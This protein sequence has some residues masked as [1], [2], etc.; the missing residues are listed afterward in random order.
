MHLW[1]RGEYRGWPD[2]TLG[3]VDASIDE[4]RLTFEG[5]CGTHPYEGRGP[6]LRSYPSG[7]V[8]ML[9]QSDSC[10]WKAA[11]ALKEGTVVGTYEKPAAP[12][13]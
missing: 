10:L 3:T 4:V 7:R 11:E 2:V 5:E 12:R 9:D 1:E 8:F 6:L 13:D